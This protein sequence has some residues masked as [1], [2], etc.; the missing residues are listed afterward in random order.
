MMDAVLGPGHVL[1]HEA[2]LPRA[3]ETV[4]EFGVDAVL[5]PDHERVKVRGGPEAQQRETGVL[6]LGGEGAGGAEEV[7]ERRGDLEE[8]LHLHAV[9]EDAQVDVKVSAVATGFFGR[10]G[11]SGGS[12][13]VAVLDD[14]RFV[15]PGDDG[16]GRDVPLEGI[17]VAVSGP[18]PVGI[19]FFKDLLVYEFVARVR[20]AIREMIGPLGLL[21]NQGIFV[22]DAQF[23][24]VK[25]GWE[26]QG[27]HSTSLQHVWSGAA[28]LV[29]M[30]P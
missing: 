20:S 23:G 11:A 29:R 7:V 30:Y 10:H 27:H 9:R 18:V 8:G 14:A 1:G 4:G 17:V 26:E 5:Q 22:Q 13:R 28:M 24:I 6:V 19:P 15:Q 12:G 21:D 3:P 16:S 2:K 25:G